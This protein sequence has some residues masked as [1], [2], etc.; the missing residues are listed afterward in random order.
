MEY[1]ETISFAVLYQLDEYNKIEKFELYE[2][3]TVELLKIKIHGVFDIPPHAQIIGGWMKHPEDD[4]TILQVCSHLNRINYLTL[5]KL[6]GI[7]HTIDFDDTHFKIKDTD[8]MEIR[9]TQSCFEQICTYTSTSNIK[10]N[11]VSL[12]DAISTALRAPPQSRKV[13]LLYLHNSESPFSSRFLKMLNEENISNILKQS[14]FFVGWDVKNKNYHN[15]LCQALIDQDMPHL[16]NFVETKMCIGIIIQ[17]I[18]G[19]IKTQGVVVEGTDESELM[20]YLN[21]SH[22]WLNADS[23]DASEDE[24]D[25]QVEMDSKA[26]QKLMA[27]R[28]GDRDFTCYAFDQHE[29]LKRNI[30]FS[31]FGPP[32]D[33][34]GYDDK[35]KK[36]IESLYQVIIKN[37]A[38][39]SEYKDQIELSTLFN[40]TE[41]LSD[42]KNSRKK[43]N[44]NYNPNTDIL[45]IPI[46]VLRKCRGSDNPCRIFIDDVGRKYENWKAYIENNKLGKCVMVLPKNGRYRVDGD[47][48]E[49]ETYYSPACGIVKNILKVADIASTV[50]SVGSGSVMLAA[51]AA[52]ITTIAVAPAALIT[53]GVVGAGA[54]VYA[55]G[56]SISNLVDRVKHEESLSFANSEA[57]GIYFN[58]LAGSVGFVG[59]GATMAVSQLAA[60][61]VNIGRGVGLA[62]NTIGVANIGVSGAS[63]INSSYDVLDQWF[64]EN[65][66]PSLLTLV[67]LSSSILFFGN[68]V[69][70]FKTCQMI[71]DETQTRVIQDY[72]ESLR[73]NR[74]RKTFNKMFKE[75]VRQNDS[76]LVRGRADV[77]K[78]IRNIPNKDD[79]FAVLTRNNRMM[80][81]KGVK[82]YA[83]EGGI[84]LNGHSINTNEFI[85]MN[86]QEASAFLSN[87]PL[88]TDISAVDQTRFINSFS[89]N[90]LPM[91]NVQHFAEYALRLIGTFGINIQGMLLQIVQ[92]ILPIVIEFLGSLMNEIFPENSAGTG[93]L[94]IVMEYF[95]GKAIEF[96]KNFETWRKTG[97]HFYYDKD[98]ADLPTNKTERYT[99]I[100][101]KLVNLCFSKGRLNQL[102]LLDIIKY[103]EKSILNEIVDYEK[104][105]EENKRRDDH[106]PKRPQEI[107]CTVCSGYYFQSGSKA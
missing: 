57:R 79:V 38:E 6:G 69:Y 76:N 80:N 74:H 87:L 105:K 2:Y 48:V 54:G 64:N 36:R 15:S 4:Q 58:L 85:I 45:P 99:W 77:I 26:F 43:K 25:A 22:N 101:V 65:Q 37:A 71:V 33:E 60:N 102:E 86:K 52:T 18:H 49:L 97:S 40:C 70:N 92:D 41:P 90:N 17:N 63:I 51:G 78:T 55:L 67:Q 50:G 59:A 107:K 14:F 28:L 72:T 23:K 98:F 100:F 16:C 30:G 8:S 34:K 35:C 7:S 75:T 31:L 3:D 66:T 20:T 13:V 103:T 81:E 68:A 47:E 91:T 11:I 9:A 106:S 61:G 12:N 44:P 24:K 94:H 104:K 53:A 42:D 73:S 89:L 83:S 10:F 84:S 62:V 56:R 19:Q 88:K 95:G 32:L 93:V 1:E 5:S 29:Y 21:N 27:D 39:I 96:L 82:F 46:F